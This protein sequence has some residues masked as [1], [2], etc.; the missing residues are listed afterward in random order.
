M[1]DDVQQALLRDIL[2]S[3]RA[4][5]RYLSGVSHEAY[6]RS[7]WSGA[8]V[9]ATLRAGSITR[10]ERVAAMGQDNAPTALA[11]ATSGLQELRKAYSS[12]KLTPIERAIWIA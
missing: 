9:G 1:L 2:D 10:A 7:G 5:Q 6:Q 4:I 3:A 12:P 11:A 8:P